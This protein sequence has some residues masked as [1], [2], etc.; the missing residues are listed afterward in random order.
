[1][2]GI[3]IAYQRH[4]QKSIQRA[5]ASRFR[6]LIRGRGRRSAAALPIADPAAVPIALLSELYKAARICFHAVMVN[7]KFA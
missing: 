3:R 6:P 4:N 5:D 7:P 2:C 1:M